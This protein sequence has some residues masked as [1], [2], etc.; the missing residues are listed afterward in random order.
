MSIT[1][2][3]LPERRRKRKNFPS[4]EVIQQISDILELLPYQLFL[5]QPEADTQIGTVIS[6]LLVI[7]QRFAK[8]ISDLLHK[9]R[10]I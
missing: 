5:E 1:I 6:D 3:Q 9:Y 8:D 2:A 7:K 4:P 10:E